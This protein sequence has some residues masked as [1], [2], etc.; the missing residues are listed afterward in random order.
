[1]ASL[2]TPISQLLNNEKEINDPTSQYGQMP[3]L[4]QE[5]HR[6]VLQQQQQMQ[7]QQVQAQQAQAMQQLNKP[8]TNEVPSGTSQGV[9]SPVKA[10]A[11]KEFFDIKSTDYKT[12][13]LVF[14]VLL[15]FTSSV[16]YGGI[17]RIFPSV[18]A[19]DGKVTLVGSFLAAIIGTLV[20]VLVKIL[21]KF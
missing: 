4:S 11:G 13:I 1:M 8:V 17:R 16:F 6:Q 21:G 20:F 2:T 7:A 5:Q 14:A 10:M 9:S 3:Q 18:L 12:Y 19:S 15:I